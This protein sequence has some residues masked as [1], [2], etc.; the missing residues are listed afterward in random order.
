MTHPGA[1]SPTGRDARLLVLDDV[2]HGAQVERPQVV[3]RAFLGMLEQLE[4][5]RAA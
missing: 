4:A 1:L 3:A 5:H 2:G